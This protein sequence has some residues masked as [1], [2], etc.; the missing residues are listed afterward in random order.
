LNPE[1]T[2][3]RYKP[4]PD[5][6]SPPQ[7]ANTYDGE[8]DLQINPLSWGIVDDTCEVLIHATL[9]TGNPANLTPGN[10]LTASARVI[11][12]PPHFAPDRRPFYSLADELADRDPESISLTDVAAGNH[13]ATAANKSA[14]GLKSKAAKRRTGGLIGTGSSEDTKNAVIDLFRRTLESAS[15]INVERQLTRAVETNSKIPADPAKRL[16]AVDK[17]TM[18]LQDRVDGK[19]FISVRAEAALSRDPGENSHG[20]IQLRRVQLAQDQHE[21]LADPEYLLRWLVENEPRL[22]DIIRPPF[23]NFPELKRRPKAPALQQLRDPR[24]LRDLQHDMRMPPYM[25]DSDYSALS[26]TRRQWE[27]IDHLIQLLK[28][29]LKSSKAPTSISS[30]SHIEARSRAYQSRKRKSGSPK[31]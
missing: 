13:A 10:T 16:P 3:C 15:L 2:W 20:D 30:F 18:T 25:R 7:P 26:I 27:Q 4:D 1:A 11:V 31:K 24:T 23:A 28:E 14:A 12:G 21:E 5:T 9:A 8:S 22:R 19:L 6:N 17:K 29:D